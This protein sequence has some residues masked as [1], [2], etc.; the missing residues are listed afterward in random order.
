MK[1]LIP[2][3]VWLLSIVVGGHANQTPYSH[4]VTGSPPQYNLSVRVMPDA[5]RLE[6]AGTVRLPAT[7]FSRDSLELSLSE[8]ME[9]FRVEIVNP[10]ASAGVARLDKSVRPH[11]RPGWGTAT[12]RVHPPRP[13]PANEPVLLRFS[14]TGG[15]ERTSFIFSLEAEVCFGAGIATAWYPE[16]EEFP[17][18]SDGRLRGLRG[19]GTLNFSVPRGYVVHAQGIQRNTPEQMAQGSFRFEINSPVFFSF[20]SGR[21]VVRRRSGTLPIALYLLRPRENAESYMDGSAR[22]LNALTQEFG[23]YPHSEFAIVEVPTAQGERAGFA[24]ASLEAF[25]MAN[26]EFLD[27]DFNTAYFGHEISHQWWGG[28]IRSKALEGRWMLSEGMAQYGSLRAVEMLE[29]AEAAERYRRTGYPGYISDQCALG[30]FMLIAKGTD[31]R[32]SDLP[33]EGDLSRALSNSKGFIILDMLSRTIGRRQF[34]RILQNFIREHAYQRVTWSEFL[35]AIETVVDRNLRWFYE[36]WFERTG[37]P[38]FQLTWRQEGRKLRGVITQ[39]SPYYQAE[40]EIEAK[41]NQG[42]HL[43]RTVRTSGAET[44][45]SFPVNFHVQSVTLDSHYLVL[46]WTPEYRAAANTSRPN[47]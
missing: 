25:I 3:T 20:A 34:S 38:D 26:T 9:D 28:L 5:R 24:G 37:A 4:P 1:K 31:H 41:N 12:W 33:Q 14:Y 22:V 15:G 23:D 13:I 47:Q 40:L 46:R 17:I 21:Y 42:Q 45:F 39:T 11:S 16:V 43:A 2:V 18:E 6:V 10:A 19:T 7:N 35:R 8:L 32:L 44:S 27:K 30:Y 36:Q 29:G